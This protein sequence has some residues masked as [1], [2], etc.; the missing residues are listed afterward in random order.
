MAAF[1]GQFTQ[2]DGTLVVQ[3]RHTV[4]ER[5]GALSGNTTSNKNPFTGVDAMKT[6]IW[7]TSLTLMA[8]VATGCSQEEAD[9][10]VEEAA[11]E[12]RETTREAW[13]ETKEATGDA[14]EATK[15]KADEA[16]DAIREGADEAGD[17]MQEGWETTKEK[18]REAADEMRDTMDGDNE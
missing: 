11:E 14:W 2:T 5:D 18:S 6:L 1:A 16:G 17:T 3:R 4:R 7:L 10:T 15:E 9:N 8:A 12:T 13:D